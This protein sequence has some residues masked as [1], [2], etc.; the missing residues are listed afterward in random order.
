MKIPDEVRKEVEI[1]APRERV[2]AALTRPEE[3]VRWFPTHLAEIDLRPGGAARF[4]WEDSSDEALVDVVE[5]PGR[6]VF[7][8]RPKGLDRPYT[9]VSFTLEE[10]SVGT[11]LTLV[12]SGF[13]S[14]PDQIA[15]QSQEGNDA[16][17]TDELAELRAYLEAA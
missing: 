4:E 13:A 3:L 17:W 5:P 11:R 8:W 1:H 6:L 15:Q 12:E 14:L 10:S 7:R 9:T 16:G 2:W